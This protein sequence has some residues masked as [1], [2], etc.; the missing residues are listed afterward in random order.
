MVQA[1]QKLTPVQFRRIK[2]VKQHHLPRRKIGA[3]DLGIESPQI[4]R[5]YRCNKNRFFEVVAVDELDGCIELQF[6]D[7]TVDEADLERWL[8]MRPEKT[9]APEDWSG[10]VDI[11]Y[12]DLPYIPP[13]LRQ[14]WQSQLDFQYSSE[15]LE[16]VD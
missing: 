1:Q 10:S 9:A 5:W 16:D 11:A 12:E 8:A 3:Q 15:P 6:F 7:G 2:L 14:D 13:L 4:G